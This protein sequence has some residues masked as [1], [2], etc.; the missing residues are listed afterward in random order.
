MQHRLHSPFVTDH[1]ALPQLLY[2]MCRHFC[3]IFSLLRASSTSTCSIPFVL[4]ESFLFLACFT[5]AL[6]PFNYSAYCT[7]FPITT[8]TFLAPLIYNLKYISVDYLQKKRSQPHLS[9]SVRTLLS[10]AFTFSS[11]FY[12]VC[13]LA[14]VLKVTI[15][16]SSL[17]VIYTLPYI[18]QQ[19]HS[20]TFISPLLYH[21]TCDLAS[22]C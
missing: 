16:S 3:S 21:L 22:C 15:S 2:I 6:F 12:F 5:L 18:V 13:G 4:R 11:L 8:C 14:C 17:L 1:I 10:F 19:Q 7:L 20:F 9:K